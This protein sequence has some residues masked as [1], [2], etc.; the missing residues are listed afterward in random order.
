MATAQEFK[1]MGISI[2][3]S[4]DREIILSKQPVLAE[5]GAGV[6]EALRKLP[7]EVSKSLLAEYGPASP[8]LITSLEESIVAREFALENA[9][10]GVNLDR[11]W[12][13]GGVDRRMDEVGLSE[14]DAWNEDPSPSP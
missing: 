12:A 7:A 5:Y 3:A 11:D 14:A 2:F 8:G 4:Q 10:S 13:K 1:S 9:A 6:R